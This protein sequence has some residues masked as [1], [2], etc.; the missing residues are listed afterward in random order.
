VVGH[1]HYV[2]SM[3]AVFAIFAGF[4]FWLEK[5]AGVKYNERLGQIHFW[6]FFIG[7]NL[8]FF[9]MH[10]LGLAGMP[11][12]ISDYPDAF[13]GWNSIASF[14]SMVSIV[15]T[16]L[17]FYIVHRALTGKDGVGEPSSWRKV[18]PRYISRRIIKSSVVLLG[19][20]DFAE[21]W[22]LTFQDPASPIME[23]IIDLHHDI[24]FFLVL[25]IVFILWMLTRII[26]YFS[27]QRNT[28]LP[29]TV[30]H[31]TTLEIIWT[32]VP[33]VILIL[34][35]I[36]SFALL[37]AMDE[38]DNP[39]LTIKSIGHQW[40]WSYEYRDLVFGQTAS[41]GFDSY[42]VLEEDLPKGGLRL[43]EVD[44]PL[45]LPINTQ[46]RLLVTSS[47]VLHSWAVP[48][49]GVKIDACPGR[50]NQVGIFI[51]RTGVF[52]G[53]CSELCGINHSFMPI[54]VI[55]YDPNKLN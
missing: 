55:A 45:V 11:R 19:V 51:N 13:I 42:M 25:I 34:I 2:L 43:L 35:A 30:S 33:A 37:Y 8:T 40:Y 54:K 6:T 5:M 29:S 38:I 52:Y 39:K 9:P 48:S 18:K 24:M 28:K 46:I 4:Y 23:G 17:F 31:H 3:G 53:Q 27:E 20:L 10:F 12:R 1:F 16:I 26:Y 7:V 21:P 32:I 14:G 50:L 15:A 47:D 49:F 22:Q 36:P 44:N 41:K